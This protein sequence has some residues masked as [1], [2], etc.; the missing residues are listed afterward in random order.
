MTNQEYLKEL[1]ETAEQVHGKNAPVSKWVRGE[2]LKAQR[3][4]LPALRAKTEVA[5]PVATHFASG[6]KMIP[7]S[8]RNPV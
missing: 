3:S 2:M 7:W 1:L 6:L 5:Q 4:P 8:C